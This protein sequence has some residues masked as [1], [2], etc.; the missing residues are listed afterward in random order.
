MDGINK[1]LEKGIQKQWK[2]TLL[3]FACQQN[4]RIDSLFLKAYTGGTWTVVKLPQNKDHNLWMLKRGGCCLQRKHM[5]FLAM[6]AMLWFGQYVYAPYFTPHLGAVGLASSVAGMVVG[7]YGFIQF[8]L[9]VPIG[10]GADRLRNHKLFMR[11]GFASMIVAAAVFLIAGD[12]AV[13]YLLAR[14][15]SGVSASTWVSF[16]VFFTGMLEEEN[17]GKAI[18]TLIVANNV[19]TLFS[20]LFGMAFYDR[21]G[22]RGLFIASGLMGVL[23]LLLL[24]FSFEENP[25]SAETMQFS[26]IPHVVRDRNLLLHA[27]LAALMQAV[28]FA[29]T[30]S[31]TATY[32]KDLGATGLQLGILAM[33]FSVFGILGSSWLSGDRH[34]RF[35][36]RSQMLLAFLL[37]A[38]SCVLIPI[39]RSIWL[40]FLAQSLAGVGRAMILTLTMAFSTYNTPPAYKTTAM[41][42]YQSLYS[43]GITLGPIAMGGILHQT[44]SFSV[45]YYI[46]AACSVLGAVWSA[47]AIRY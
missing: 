13:L 18:G 38:V 32:A 47:C 17:N 37:L 2:N 23:G 10:I 6:V 28:I 44:G 45:A 5:Q 43:I 9:R 42:L 8:C 31:F 20:Y 33:L 35:T 29:T 16:T 22:I 24:A 3:A 36:Y 12:N 27:G 25:P 30:Q 41:G 40:V 46:M 14:L 21:I 34:R 39:S 7:I 19:G 15:L 1:I 26:D 11:L 4:M